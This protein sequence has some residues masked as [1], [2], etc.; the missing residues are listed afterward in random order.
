MIDNNCNFGGEQ[1]GHI[2]LSDHGITGDGLISALKILEYM[3]Y[4]NKSSFEINN[5][6]ELYPQKLINISY[7]SHGYDPLSDSKFLE[8]IDEQNNKLGF[9]GRI[10]ARKSGTQD[11][12]RILIESNNSKIIDNIE[13]DINNMLKL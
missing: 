13:K 1:S 2:I 3:I 11:L 6:F 5:L 8:Y 7:N 4:Y 10:F 9:K 12:I